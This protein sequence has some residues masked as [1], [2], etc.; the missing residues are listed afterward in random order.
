M[1]N[2]F[3]PLILALSLSA[4]PAVAA[5]AS[6]SAA[7]ALYE[8]RLF[9]KACESYEAAAKTASGDERLRAVYRAVESRALTFAY[10]EAAQLLLSE[11]LPQNTVWR[12]RFLLLKAELF[13]QYLTQYGYGL[14]ADRQEGS[15][16]VTKWT[17]AQWHEQIAAS[18]EQLWPLRAALRD[19][20]LEQESYFIRKGEPPSEDFPTLWDF[21]VYRWT[22]YL[23]GQAP[24]GELLPDAGS[25][26]SSK[27]A[28]RVDFAHPPAKL[29]AA[30]MAEA[31]GASNGKNRLKASEVWQ[32]KRLLIPFEHQNKVRAPENMKLLRDRAI[33]ILQSWMELFAVPES[34][35]DT[36][37]QAALFLEQNQKYAQ[38]VA[39]CQKADSLWHGTLGAR[40]CLNIQARIEMPSLSLSARNTPPSG[41]KAFS[42]T[43]RNVERI[44]CKLYRTSQEE[45]RRLSRRHVDRD[46]SHLL[47]L[48]Q[49]ALAVFLDKRPDREWSESPTYS[50]PYV[51]VS[52]EADAP[53]LEPGLY[54]LAI[55]DGKSFRTGSDILQ[56]GIINCTE[57]FLLG[58]SGFMAKPAE[59]F[60]DP[61]QGSRN[62]S[63]D[64]FHLYAVNALNGKPLQTAAVRAYY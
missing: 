31:A 35:A 15:A 22:D 38:A 34:K 47:G 56:A 8:K 28:D 13:R 55:S 42:Y 14:P 21:A 12:A 53:S 45:L 57:I 9:T 6:L 19:V 46:Y 16:D 23:L 54:V 43:A 44:Y 7:D 60:F 26:V 10:G 17:S 5:K 62:F 51:Y 29:A 20:R 49:Q 64:G 1:K 41:K 11:P 37:A 3:M 63:A 52:G 36:A 48:D 58:S 59:L 40:K 33:E 32:L 2:I 61:R 30:L 50:A 4:Q 27:Y 24:E 39:L 18:Y 25:F